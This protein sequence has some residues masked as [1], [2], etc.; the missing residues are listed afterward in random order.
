MTLPQY[1]MGTQYDEKMAS[2]PRE[3]TVHGEERT[4][5]KKHRALL[6]MIVALA[7]IYFTTNSV[8]RGLHHDHHA[9]RGEVGQAVKTALDVGYRHIDDARV[10]RNE[11]EVGAAVFESGYKREDVWLTSKLWNDHHDPR[12][13][14]TL[15]TTYLDLFLIHWPIAFNRDGSVY[16]KELTDDPFPTWQKME[17]MVA[18]GKVRNIGV[19]NFNIWRLSKLLSHPNIT[20]PP[21]INQVELNFYNPQPGLLAWAK[22]HNILIEAYS[23]LGGDGQVGRT[24]NLPVVKEI[25]AELDITPAQVIISWHV[26][27]GT[28]VLPKS[29]TPA[30]I[31][32]N[33][34]VTRLPDALFEK[35]EAAAVG[36][37]PQ[38]TL[39]P[40]ESWGLPFDLFE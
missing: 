4:R 29:V 23:P 7:I 16:N 26:Q 30:R 37:K 15:N 11:E 20:I 33:L 10:Y 1:A 31:E 9:G 34:Q 19:S 5:R 3:E 22:E 21:A 8:R 35:L 39:N 6:P 36:H 32:E 24:L 17:E 28:V 12:D 38:R 14:E 25:A 40:S 18:K 13:V 2:R 27:R